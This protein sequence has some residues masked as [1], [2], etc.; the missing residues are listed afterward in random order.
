[1]LLDGRENVA[2]RPASGKWSLLE[3]VAHLFAYQRQFSRRIDRILAEEHP[4]FEA[5]VGDNDPV[6]LEA[7]TESLPDLLADLGADRLYLHDR[8]V[9][10]SDQQMARTAAH[11]RYGTRTLTSWT[12][13]FLLHEAHHLFTM[14]KL[15]EETR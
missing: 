3:N 4:L 14:W 6:Y 1:M 13:F 5:Y 9:S 8:L 7:C 2:T 10:L 12:E 11:P 15:L